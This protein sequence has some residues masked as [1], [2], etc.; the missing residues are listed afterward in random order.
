MA[1][2]TWSQSRTYEV[3]N[4]TDPDIDY[5][6]NKNG[7]ADITIYV[8][9]QRIDAWQ[10]FYGR[11]LTLDSYSGVTKVSFTPYDVPF[12]KNDPNSETMQDNEIE[13]VGVLVVTG[14]PNSSGKIS[15]TI[16]MT[17][18]GL[19]YSSG[20]HSST[21]TI[22]AFS[23]ISVTNK[24]TITYNANGGSGTAPSSHSVTPG[25]S[26]TLRDNTFTRSGY[27]FIGWG[28]STT[29]TSVRQPGTSYTPDKTR[30]F[31]AIWKQG[32]IKIYTSDGWKDAIP[33]V[34]TSSGW[35]KAIPYV[36]KSST[37]GWKASVL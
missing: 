14:T 30:T 12:D 29:S 5:E 17:G 24:Y 3:Y 8:Y 32:G 36:Y 20:K 21:I 9:A 35:K 11:S 34:Y 25:N 7:T 1:S 13:C 23:G 19:S 4:F 2:C 31:Y 18:T 15:C 28:T 22:S 27:V 33:Y 10:P 26:I 37:D 6:D 16:K